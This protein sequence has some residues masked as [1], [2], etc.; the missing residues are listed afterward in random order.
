MSDRLFDRRIKLRHIVCFLEVARLKSVGGAATLLGVTQPAASK[1]I[2]ELEDILGVALFDRS[3]RNLSLTE[4][5]EVFLRYAGAGVTALR[6]GIDSID[7]AQSGGLVVKVAA[8]PT[9]SARILPDAVR[10]FTAE[11]LKCRVRVVTG[12]NAYLLSLLRLGDAD[13]VVGRMAAPE[14]MTGFSFEHLY[15]EEVRLVVRAGHPL[16]DRKP[17]DFAMIERYPVLMPPPGSIIR[18]VVERLLIAHGIARIKDEVETVSNA[19]GR[20]FTRSSDAIWIISEGVVT[21]DLAEGRLA[22][23]PLDTSET[24]GPVGLTTRTDIAPTLPANLLMEALRDVAANIG[25]S[26][27]A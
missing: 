10:R 4:A 21:E 15:S 12:P 17:F 23:L 7:Q 11:G 13:F 14:E 20:S 25:R 18:P 19:F 24:L 27:K 22:I 8:L 26:A 5:G 6:Q 2:L 9:A 1:T 16:L 3:R